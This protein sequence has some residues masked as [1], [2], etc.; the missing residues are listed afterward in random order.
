MV[1]LIFL[2]EMILM[3]VLTWYNK[4]NLLKVLELLSTLLVWVIK[5]NNQ[6]LTALL[7]RQPISS[8]P[9]LMIF[10]LWNQLSLEFWKK[11][12]QVVPLKLANPS[13]LTVPFVHVLHVFVP[14]TIVTVMVEPSTP[15][16]V[17][18]KIARM[19][20]VVLFVVVVS[21]SV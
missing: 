2:K 5:L 13:V 20:R 21:S 4:Q 6:V 8:P 16:H 17:L 12:V 14:L 9:V 11:S 19:V 1:K 10:L 15:P 7:A 18:A 3:L